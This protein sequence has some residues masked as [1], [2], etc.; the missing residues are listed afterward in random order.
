MPPD[1]RPIDRLCLLAVKRHCLDVGR[2]ERRDSGWNPTMRSTTSCLGL[3]LLTV[4]LQATETG[5]ELEFRA[6]RDAVLC[7]AL[8]RTYEWTLNSISL[9]LGDNEFQLG[10]NE[11]D[12]SPYV[13]TLRLRGEREARWCDRWER[14]QDGQPL[15]YQRTIEA[16]GGLC[17]WEWV[18]DMAEGAQF[19]RARMTSALVDADLR[20]RRGD[21]G[22]SFAVLAPRWLEEADYEGLAGAVGWCGVLPGAPVSA[23][24]RWYVAGAD[25]HELLRP[26]GRPR[27]ELDSCDGEYPE[28]FALLCRTLD[29][30]AL[31]EFGDDRVTV[32]YL[33]TAD[34]V[35]ELELALNSHERL[36]LAERAREDAR[37]LEID[38]ETRSCL[39]RATLDIDLKG[40]GRLR[41]ST[42]ESRPVSA[43]LRGTIQAELLLLIDDPWDMRI[44]IGFDGEFHETLSFTHSAP[45]CDDAPS[46]PKNGTG[47]RR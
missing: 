40:A 33:S 37:A 15:T 14:V 30:G 2:R 18:C 32:R 44:R 4:V 28:L 9:E 27:M 1:P 45:E 43:E 46:R 19:G 29:P 3:A 13:P 5:D 10:D 22:W 38:E 39:D 24:T 31:L 23:G 34:G 35:A 42:D 25:M 36:E 20:A 17:E 7:A 8:E 12:L 6:T 11:F 47:P 26:L 21:E 41:W 16:L